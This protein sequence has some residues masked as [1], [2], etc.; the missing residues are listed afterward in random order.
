MHNHV[1]FVKTLE[2]A[3]RR[4]A[5]SAKGKQWRPG[6]TID[7]F[8]IGGTTEQRSFVQETAAEWLKYANL[9]FNYIDNIRE[10]DVRISFN[11]RDGAWS[12]VGTT[13]LGIPDEFATMN[14]GWLDKSTVLH[15][16]GHM[17]G[18][19]HEHQNPEGGLIWN[20]KA[21][22]KDLMGPPNNWNIQQIRSNVL[23]NPPPDSYN[24][25]EFDPLSIM[26]YHFPNHWVANGRG[27]R[28]NTELSEMD[29]DWVMRMYPPVGRIL[30]P[31]PEGLLIPPDNPRS[32]EFHWKLRGFSSEEDIS[33]QALK[34]EKG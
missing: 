33:D 1:C 29:K 16:F 6:E 2:S 31:D 15:E 7:I 12:Y 24:G 9:K 21:V 28:E 26:L 11:D 20:E 8:F 3:N 10:S 27:T 14:L 23:D 13:C 34:D 19:L 30:L 22:I 17:I 18:L 32:R 5:L 4:Y 25:T